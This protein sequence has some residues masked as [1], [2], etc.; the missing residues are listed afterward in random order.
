MDTL[1][2]H[3]LRRFFR[4]LRLDKKDIVFIYI[5]SIFEGI[6]S[7]TIPVGIQAIINL[8]ALNQVSSSWIVL[9][10]IVAL[11]TGVA[12]AMKL[13]QHIITET[14]QQRIFT[15][16]A[17]DFAYRMPRLQMESIKDEYAPELANRFFD[18]LS[19]QKGIPKILVDLSAA[20]LQ[21]IFGLI[22]LSLYHPFF[23]FFGFILLVLIAIIV[24]STFSPG[25]SS[26]LLES[27]YKYKISRKNT[28]S[29]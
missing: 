8:I 5:Y 22:L 26:S 25:L 24:L 18:T 9:T 11:G 17:F 23:V 15:R 14:I 13:M 27:K 21:I 1:K 4:L 10:F 3:P 12:G 28:I 7:L 19:I 2:G 20:S 29:S 6:I 16:S